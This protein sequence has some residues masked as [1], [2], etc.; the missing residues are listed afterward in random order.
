MN[1]NRL[2]KSIIEHEGF[3]SKIYTC[4]A[5]KL[6]IGY[7]RN[8]EDRGITKREADE[9]LNSDCLDIKL[10]LED[11]IYFFSSLPDNVQ[12]VLVEM[13][14]QLGV[15]GL[16]KFKNTISYLET[17]YLNLING[18][19]RD[20]R[21]YVAKAS[22]EMLNSKWAIQTPIRAKKLSQKIKGY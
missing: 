20:Y 10:K 5:G 2:K 8:L 21:E 17:A 4:P 6:T 14:Y 22:I 13:A 18:R 16:L 9:F 11:D 1:M 19:D 12:E 15:F 3:S 7:G